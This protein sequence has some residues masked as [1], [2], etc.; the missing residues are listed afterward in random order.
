MSKSKEKTIKNVVK[1]SNM[2]K[3]WEKAS[4]VAKKAKNVKNHKKLSKISKN[5]QKF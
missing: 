1:S 5:R 2:L 3:S 4:K